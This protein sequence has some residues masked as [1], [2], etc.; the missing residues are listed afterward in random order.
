[1]F[2]MSQAFNPAFRISD[3]VCRV[4]PEYAVDRGE[5]RRE[6]SWDDQWNEPLTFE[7]DHNRLDGRAVA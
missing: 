3:R 1:M 6:G 4:R 7:L 2:G 5:C